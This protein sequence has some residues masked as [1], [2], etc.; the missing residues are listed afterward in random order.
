MKIKGTI[1]LKGYSVRR[2]NKR[3]IY[4]WCSQIGMR[5]KDLLLQCPKEGND[6]KYSLEVWLS[7]IRAHIRYGSETYSLACN[8]TFLYQSIHQPEEI[9]KKNRAF[10]VVSPVGVSLH[11]DSEENS[12]F[13]GFLRFHEIVELNLIVM[14][15]LNNC[16]GRLSTGAGW[17]TISS[18]TGQMILMELIT[19]ED[20]Q[21]LSNVEIE[22][23]ENN[24]PIKQDSNSDDGFVPS[25]CL[26]KE[27]PAPRF[28]FI[29]GK[30]E[31]LSSTGTPRVLGTEQKKD[32][33]ADQLF[34]SSED[35]ES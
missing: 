33:A 34:P 28:S 18:A 8:W 23:D 11:S 21:F 29:G 15:V 9:K 22:F 19:Q 1:P 25:F 2:E 3:Q 5:G 32:S 7:A 30:F 24:E 4:L 14:N 27:G 10:Q 20:K 6:N 31:V 35:Q 17:V 26:S 16:R 12:E 13:V